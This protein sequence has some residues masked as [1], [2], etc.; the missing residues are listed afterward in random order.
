MTAPP[1]HWERGAG[2]A[3]PEESRFLQGP[4]PRGFELVRAARIFW[5]LLQ[6]FRA[7]HFVGPCVTVFGSA[8]FGEGTPYYAIGRDL[9]ARL[10]RAGFTVMTG[11]GPG[12][13]ESVNRGAKD[14]G[15]RSVGCNIVLPKERKPNPYLDRWVT[16]R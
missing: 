12:L 8:R 4:Q 9:G 3:A 15:G 7:L 14:V 2:L 16:F 6:G 10:A 11:G 13:M 5:E 1:E